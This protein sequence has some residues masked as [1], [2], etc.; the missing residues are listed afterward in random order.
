MNP[1][2][3]R[4]RLAERFI[5]RYSGRVQRFWGDQAVANPSGWGANVDQLKN[6]SASADAGSG[7]INFDR[8]FLLDS[9][10]RD[11]RGAVIHELTHAF[12]V[13]SQGNGNAVETKADYARYM[14]NPAEAGYWNPSQAVLAMADKLGGTPV[15]AGPNGGPPVGNNRRDRNTVVNNASHGATGQGYQAP[16]SSASAVQYGNDLAAARYQYLAQLA[17]LRMQKPLI[18]QDY[19]QGMLNARQAGIAGVGAAESA[20][21]ASGMLGSSADLA[22][23]AGAVGQMTAD[24]AAAMQG[25]NQARLGLGGQLIDNRS[26]YFQTLAG[27]NNAMGQEQMANTINA[28][29]DNSFG[30]YGSYQDYLKRIRDQKL[31]IAPRTRQGV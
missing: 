21:I 15:S 29:G 2:E 22:A 11:L 9:S 28:F 5:N 1:L 4:T 7:T 17:A 18:R 19:R 20:G 16:V 23:R 25:Y 6:A 12:G 24:Q 13:G 27:I 31:G 14:L 30:N 3:R 26:Q 8:N 10:K